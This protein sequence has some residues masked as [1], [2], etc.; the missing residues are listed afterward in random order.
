M[1]D[2]VLCQLFLHIAFVDW[3]VIVDRLNQAASWHNESK[4][5]NCCIHKFSQV[6]FLT[7]LGLLI[8]AAEIGQ[9]GK[10]LWVM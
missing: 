1:Q 9:K 10:E 2:V 4:K 7:G 3:T 8:G 5:V 6:E